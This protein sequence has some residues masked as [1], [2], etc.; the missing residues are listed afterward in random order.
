[1]E[2]APSHSVVRQSLISKYGHLFVLRSPS[3]PFSGTPRRDRYVLF[4]LGDYV[5]ISLATPSIMITAFCPDWRMGGCHKPRLTCCPTLPAWHQAGVVLDQEVG[6][7][8]LERRGASWRA[9]MEEH[10]GTAAAAAALHH[11][12]THRQT[13]AEVRGCMPGKNTWCSQPPAH[14]TQLHKQTFTSCTW[15]TTH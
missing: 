9:G 3:S 14:F 4:L 2:G 7:K 15:R 12:R 6:M 13:S 5:S 10:A 8:G 1:M 11:A